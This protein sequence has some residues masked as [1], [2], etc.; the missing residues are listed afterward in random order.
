MTAPAAGPCGPWIE[1]ADVTACCPGLADPPN[2]AAV[3]RGIAFATG[4]LWALSGRQYPGLCSR[5]VRPCYGSNCGCGSMGW[6]QW[7][8]GGWSMWTWDAA[9]MGWAFPTIPV[10]VGGQFF[11]IGG[12][13]CCAGECILPSVE[14][15]APIATVEQVVIDGVV[16]P[17]LDPVTGNENYAIEQFMRL[18]RRDGLS[19]PCSQDRTKPSDPYPGAPDGS[20]DGTWQVTYTYG[21]IP[22]DAGLIAVARFACE[23]A[24]F[25][26]G[27]DNCVLPQ[28]LTH[29]S[30]EGVDLDFAD[31]LKFLDED[32]RVGIYEVDLWLKAF[33]PGGLVRRSTVRRLDGRGTN[34][35]GFTG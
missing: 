23:V 33:N 29:I 32:G 24:K 17:R 34:S 12:T 8:L 4:I 6:A 21:R 1:P 20:R 15:P 3:E 16:F 14:L 26:C 7:P 11:N 13:G 28:R 25:L 9:A 30:R 31:P 22:D 35:R 18:V 10:L 27:A 19:W 5:I 2:A